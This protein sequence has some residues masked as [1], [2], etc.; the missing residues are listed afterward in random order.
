M[1]LGVSWYPEQHPADRWADDVRRMA[2][3]GLSLVR[4][5]EFGWGEIEPSRGRFAWDWLD[6]AIDLAA[7]AGLR[8]LLGTPTSV[9]PVWLCLARPE[10]LSVAPD[11]L[12]QEYGSRKFTCPTA[13]A[14]REESRRIVE[15]LVERYGRHEAVEAWQVDN[16]PGNHG[17]AWCWC[18]AS[19]RAFRGWL[20]RRYGTIEA[21]NEAWGTVFWSGR[22][23]SFDAV[24]LP[25]PTPAAHHPSLLL[26]HRRFSSD[27][28][29]DGL[30]EQQAL[31]ARG[32]PG[33]TILSNLPATGTSLDPRAVA[34][35]FGLAAINV[36]PTGQGSDEDAAF[37]LD[38]ARGHT[39]R[40][41]ITEQQPG[42]INWTPSR[43]AVAA[44]RVRL[45]GWRAALHGIDACLFFSWRPARSGSEQ[46]HA[47]LLRHDG[48][49]GQGLR[50]AE[51]LARELASTS[52]SV[53]RRP[54]PS[55][56]LLWSIDDDWAIE[57]GPHRPDLTHRA[58]VVAAHAAAQR[59]GLEV[60]VV[61]PDDDLTAY[62]VVLAPALVIA[63][64][65]RLAR[66]R[67]ALDAG[68]LVVLG[69]RS[70][71]KDEDDCRLEEALPAGLTDALGAR[72]VESVAADDALRVEPFGTEAGPWADVLEASDAGGEVV[73]SYAGGP[74]DG[75]PA[76]VR[77]GNLAY[78]GFT[79][80]GAWIGLL[81]KLL[82]G[83]LPVA[84]V[85]PARERF[86]RAGHVIELDHERVELDGLRFD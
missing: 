3:A 2:S 8:V 61:A 28:V 38:L 22:Y 19:E 71:V 84:D 54:R 69:A 32:A 55:V 17:S 60:D 56:A 67:E 36:Y 63:T 12:P 70:L 45:W 24:R 21:L 6:R 18:D 66:L 85:P 26:A 39:G 77:A 48:A 49:A 29:V 13:P 47:G 35:R 79:A 34:R 80:T 58:L 9:P 76:A 7:G 42:P 52:P 78:A 51:R 82:D 11:G 4:L 25:R 68:A 20:E 1:R 72:V 73:A 23:P 33:R 50:E 15:A 86:E 44:G 46:E 27:E 65:A 74:L 53:L 43:D 14:Y 41:W 83:R 75:L 59:L 81:R 57:I 30:A 40:A 64:P 10:I 62:R 37:L 31:I 16:E 5:G